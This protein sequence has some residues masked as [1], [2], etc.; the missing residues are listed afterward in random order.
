MRRHYAF[1]A[2]NLTE[3]VRGQLERVEDAV[4]SKCTSVSACESMLARIEAEEDKFN[5]ALESMVNSAKAAQSGAIDRAT[6]ASQI[7]PVSAELKEIADNIGVATESVGVSQNELNDVRA[8]ISGAKEIVE[9]KLDELSRATES[10]EGDK[11]KDDKDEDGKDDKGDDKKDDKDSKSESDGDKKDDKDSKSESDDGEE[12]D[13]EKDDKD[14]DN[15]DGEEAPAD[16]SFTFDGVVY[17]VESPAFESAVMTLSE[18]DA[19]AMEGYNWDKKAQYKQIMDTARADIKDARSLANNGKTDE[20][21]KK[22]DDAKAKIKSALDGFKKACREEQDGVTA[23]IGFFAYSL[24]AIGFAIIASI[25]TFGLGGIAVEIKSNVE[26]IV[27]II[28]AVKKVAEGDELKAGD[29]NMYTKALEHNMVIMMHYI[30]NVKTN[31]KGKASAAAASAP[32]TSAP[33]QESIALDGVD[34]IVGSPAYESMLNSLVGLDEVAMEGYNWDQKAKYKAN[35]D[36]AKK[37]LNAANTYKRNGDYDRALKSIDEGI[38]AAEASLKDF[39]NAQ[40]ENQTAGNAICGFFAYGWRAL[41]H[42]F[43]LGLG[44]GVTGGIAGIPAAVTAAVSTIA[45]NI[46]N[47]VDAIAQIAE[48][49][50]K[51]ADGESLSPA[52]FNRYTKSLEN[53]MRIMIARMKQARKAIAAKQNSS[54]AKADDA[55]TDDAKPASESEISDEDWDAADESWAAAVESCID[56]A[57]VA[58][59]MEGANADALAAI[60]EHNAKMRSLKKEFRSLNK[61]K[62]FN[63]AAAKASEMAQLCRDSKAKVDQIPAS[64]GSAVI[65]NLGMALLGAASGAAIGAVTGAGAL[66]AAGAA[67]GVKVTGTAAAGAALYGGAA[68]AAI[69]AVNKATDAQSNTLVRLLQKKGI[70]NGAKSETAEKVWVVNREDLGKKLDA[71]DFNAIIAAIKVDLTKDAD[72]WDRTAKALRNKASG[73]NES[74]GD[75]MIDG[76]VAACESAMIQKSDAPY[77]FD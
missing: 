57:T 54:A 50:K 24:R 76:F 22:L 40:R 44:V 52:D 21:L 23:V 5:G 70:A 65:A 42:S 17:S 53:N 29:L 39:Q 55:K 77:L 73:A 36:K 45:M 34:F 48:G 15:G 61:A 60:K 19:I 75:E 59:A 63:G 38:A 32:A 56:E 67:T 4:D 35:I 20:A 41:G 37:A 72:S 66:A 13:K 2:E 58:A 26:V 49:V 64:V 74:F 1:E 14:G 46:R 51:S 11:P 3:N 69:G 33:A 18:I 30:D 8:Y 47:A 25:P 9:S 71:N 27:D 7:A 43:L 6:M 68:G 12:D 28:E 62:D 16:E 10:D 31:I